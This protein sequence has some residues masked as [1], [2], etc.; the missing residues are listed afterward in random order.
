MSNVSGPVGRSDFLLPPTIGDTPRLEWISFVATKYPNGK[1]GEE[2]ST[3]HN[4]NTVKYREVMQI[5][6]GGVAGGDHE[7]KRVQNR[8]NQ[9]K[10]NRKTAYDAEATDPILNDFKRELIFHRQ[11]QSAT[12]EGIQRLHELGV[13]MKRPNSYFAAMAKSDEH[14]QHICK[15]LQDQQEG[16]GKSERMKHL[17][18]KRQIGKLTQLYANRKRDEERRKVLNGVRKFRKGKLTNLDLL[19]DVKMELEGVRESGKRSTSKRQTSVKLQVQD[20]KFGSSERKKGL[21]RN[22]KESCMLEGH[23]SKKRANAKR[24]RPGKTRRAQEKSRRGRVPGA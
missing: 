16:I 15:V 13:A 12:C 2:E 4:R 1:K 10:G 14:M 5:G 19:N 7:R 3:V 20:A 21:K 9:L 18:E 23:R 17:R 8:E 24:N 11:A 6:A 22:T